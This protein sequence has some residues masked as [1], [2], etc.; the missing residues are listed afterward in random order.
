MDKSQKMELL[1]GLVQVKM[2]NIK[3][4]AMFVSYAEKAK[5]FEDSTMTNLFASHAK[6][7][8]QSM[9]ELDRHC[10]RLMRDIGDGEMPNE[11]FRHACKKWEKHN[12]EDLEKRLD[13]LM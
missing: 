13:K 1:E 10:D 6:A 3:D 9:D 12:I 7:R 5:S 11:M 8:I 4:A 2:D